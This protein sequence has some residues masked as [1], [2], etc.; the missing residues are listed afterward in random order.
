MQAGTPDALLQLEAL[1]QDE[2][3][4]VAHLLQLQLQAQVILQL[5]LLIVVP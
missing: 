5:L 2:K 4:L 3:A 1:A